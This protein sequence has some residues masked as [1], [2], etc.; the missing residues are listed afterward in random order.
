MLSGLIGAHVMF[1]LHGKRVHL[2]IVA[3]CV[4][5]SVSSLS[6]HV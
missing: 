3:A 1:A 6:W 2:E 5:D 4:C